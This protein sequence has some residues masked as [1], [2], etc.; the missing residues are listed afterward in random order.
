MVQQQAGQRQNADNLETMGSASWQHTFSPN[1]VFDT[2][3]L[4]RENA[5][6]FFSNPQSTPIVVFQHNWFRE[7]YFKAG[8]TI[9][10]GR[11]EWKAGVESDNT[12]LNE[13]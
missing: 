7:G 9:D 13:N 11:N 12:F 6:D 3:G 2:H 1:A 4:V 5:N 10:Q 8:V